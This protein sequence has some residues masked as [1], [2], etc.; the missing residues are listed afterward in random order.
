M[1][2][3]KKL[4][5]MV[6][7]GTMGIMLA[8]AGGVASAATADTAKDAQGISYGEERVYVQTPEEHAKIQANVTR[9]EPMPNSP[10]AL[11]HRKAIGADNFYTSDKV[12]KQKVTFKNIYDMNIAGTLVLPKDIKKGEKLAAVVVGHPMG[13]VKEQSSTLYATKLAE[14]GIAALAIDLSYWGESEG[15]QGKAASSVAPDMYA[16]DFSAAVDYLG[17][18]D[19]IDRDKIGVL[20]I[21]GSGSFA[22]SAAKIDPRMK[23]VATVSMYNMGQAARNGLN[24][25]VDL[26]TRKAMIADAANAR[27]DAF[28]GKGKTKLTSGTDDKITPNMN[29]IQKE[30]YDF[31]R[32][33]RATVIPK[34]KTLEQTTHPT[35]ISM[36]KFMNFYPFNDMNLLDDRPKMFI[37]GTEAH[38]LEFSQEAY[39]LSGGQKELVLVPNAGHVDLY[40]GAGIIPWDKLI[41]FF[42][43]NLHA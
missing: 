2:N 5:A 12:T 14:Q 8:S 7:M 29:D 38:S 3:L 6:L 40:D 36:T 27:Y 18:R 32:T 37:A 35:L 19:Y 24:H 10:E 1:K 28:L 30:F 26:Q 39:A 42:K 34:G 13:A 17:T 43:T 11:A 20:G 22:I 4:K 16:E 33:D 9:K 21:C 31:Y 23:A 41:N 15:A 25:S